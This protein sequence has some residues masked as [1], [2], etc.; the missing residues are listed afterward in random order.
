MPRRAHE[1]RDVVQDPS[2]IL[3]TGHDAGLIGRGV[4]GVSPMGCRRCPQLLCNPRAGPADLRPHTLSP[5]TAKD[6]QRVRP[7]PAKGPLSSGPG[8]L[9]AEEVGGFDLEV[10]VD[11]DLP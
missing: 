2:D 8:R 4:M 5:F 11:D 1:R 9:S 7:H 3:V 6:V 10:E